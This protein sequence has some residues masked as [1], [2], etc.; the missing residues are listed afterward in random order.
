MAMALVV[1]NFALLIRDLGTS[2]AIIQK[3]ELHNSVVTLIFKVNVI[4]GLIIA[5]SLCALAPAIARLFHEER[6]SSV[7][8]FLSM[9]FPIAS[10]S[11]VH[12]ALLER[13]SF[14]SSIARIEIISG[15][16]GLIVA[17]VFAVN[18][19]GVYSLVAQ[20]LA[21]ASISSF[22]LWMTS[23]WRPTS[24]K[25]AREDLSLLINFS[26][27]L[28]AFNFINYFARNADGMIIGHYLGAALLGAYSLAYRL[29]MFPLQNLTFV[30]SRALL[31]VISRHGSDIESTRV[32]YLKVIAVIAAV[33]APLMFGLA[34][35]REPFVELAFGPQWAVTASVV[36]WLAPAG[37]V[38][39]IVSTT[40]TIFVAKGR[41]DILFRVGIFNTVTQVGAFV[42]GAQ[43]GLETLV[44]L[45]LLANLIN[46][47]P[48]IYFTMSQIGGS[49]L[50]VVEVI[51]AP[52]CSAVVMAAVIAALSNALRGNGVDLVNWSTFIGLV[53]VGALLYLSLL[54]FSPKY[55]R[56]FIWVMKGSL[57]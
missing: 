20:S 8:F 14:F 1:T 11:S 32:I 31:P 4:M 7:L 24:G 51:V 13:A 21:T 48:S 22:Q 37:F 50:Q 35:L 12:Q 3:K 28:T 30:T 25:T 19:A 55:R 45:Y 41:T 44:K 15:V 23:K 17:V 53:F 16:V 6:L 47:V 9:S 43:Y 39:S 33:I 18:G 54:S 46:S 36:L 38:Q 49:L 2:S 57:K 42:V 34:A 10:S 40:G 52:L 26:G 56:D 5:A 27:N 29:M